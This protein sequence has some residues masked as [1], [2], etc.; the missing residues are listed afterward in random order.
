MCG[1]GDAW[2]L[3]CL[4]LLVRS[5]IICVCRSHQLSRQS[6]EMSHPTSR[7]AE[8]TAALSVYVDGSAG[9]VPPC[10]VRAR[11]R[12]LADTPEA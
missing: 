4:D 1:L 9:V 8:P 3:F 12:S 6:H 5:L 2:D 7:R 10:L 11:R